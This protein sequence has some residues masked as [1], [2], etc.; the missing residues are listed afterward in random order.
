MLSPNKLEVAPG[1]KEMALKQPHRG[2]VVSVSVF[3]LRTVVRA[4]IWAVYAMKKYS[5][6]RRAL[7]RNWRPSEWAM[8]LVDLDSA[9]VRLQH[10]TDNKEIVDGHGTPPEKVGATS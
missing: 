5:T 2:R 7:S 4:A 3:D 1:F 8:T 9:I 6:M 10:A